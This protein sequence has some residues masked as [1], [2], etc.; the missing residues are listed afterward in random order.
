VKNKICSAFK[1]YLSA[2]IAIEYKSCLYFFAILFFYCVY[3]IYNGIYTARIL[4]MFEMILSAYI[5]GYLQ[6]YVLFNFD[7]AQKL[8]VRE[9]AAIFLCTGLYTAASFC[10]GWFE[11]NVAVSG[12]FFFYLLFMYWCAYLVNKVKRRVDTENLNKML[13]EFKKDTD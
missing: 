1:R 3:L 8:S 2:E 9:G 12:L 13:Q 11:Q 7:E 6:V 5:M 10:F 4:Y